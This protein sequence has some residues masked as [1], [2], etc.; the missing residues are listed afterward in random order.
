MPGG[1][2]SL[3]MDP[4]E[5]LLGSFPCA[6][7]R[8]IPYEA[9]PEDVLVFFRGLVVIDVVLVSLVCIYLSRFIMVVQTR[10]LSSPPSRQPF[11]Y[12]GLKF[13]HVSFVRFVLAAPC[14]RCRDHRLW[15]IN[16]SRYS[17]GSAPTI[18]RPSHR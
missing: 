15:G 12:A 9:T 14:L 10:F 7:V 1:L 18:T 2:S 6:R 16:T 17:K 13:R 3:S 5:S 8:G 11:F 4:L